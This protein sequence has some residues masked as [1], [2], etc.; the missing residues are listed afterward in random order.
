MATYKIKILFE[1]I[2]SPILDITEEI[3]ADS[4]DQA[5]DY[6]LDNYRELIKQ[7]YYQISIEREEIIY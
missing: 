2:D 6:M 7:A 3:E 1:N 4:D 5:I